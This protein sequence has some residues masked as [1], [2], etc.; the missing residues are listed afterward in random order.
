MGVWSWIVGRLPGLHRLSEAIEDICA[1][2]SCS[3][4]GISSSQTEL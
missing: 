4:C 1:D 3:V 2:D